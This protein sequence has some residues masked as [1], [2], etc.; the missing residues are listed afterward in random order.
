MLLSCYHGSYLW[1]NHRII[2]DPMLFNWI[3]WLSMQG[4]N[5]QEFYPRKSMDHTLAQRI[6]DTNGDVKKGMRYYKVDSMQ[7]GIVH[8]TYQLIAGKLVRKN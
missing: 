5:S 3:M 4:P 1:L 8:L 7:S 2:V 6:K